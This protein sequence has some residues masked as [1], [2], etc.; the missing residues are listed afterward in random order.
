MQSIDQ[1]KDLF[2]TLNQL[3]Q[4]SLLKELSDGMQK[5]AEKYKEDIIVKCPF[6]QSQQIV[7]NGS[8]NGKQKYKCKDC[9][10]SYS[11]YTGTSS[12]GIKKRDK[13]EEYKSVLL[14]EGLFP[15]KKMASRIGISEQ[16]AFDWRHKILCTLTTDDTQFNGIVEIDDIWFLY[17]QKGR[18]GLKYSRKR[19]GSKRKGDNNY[20]AKLLVTSDREGDHDLSLTRI[21]RL[22]SEDI[23]RKVGGR[24]KKEATLVSDKH[25]SI[26]AFAK[27]NRIKHVSF[28]SS[29]HG[30]DKEHHVQLVNNMASRL[31]NFINGNLKG[32]STKHLQCYANWFSFIEGKKGQSEIIKAANQ[33]LDQ[34]TDSWNTFINMESMY[35]KF[36]EEYSVRTYRCPT[37]RKW[38]NQPWN[39][40]MIAAM[41]YV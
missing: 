25:S 6:C 38:K 3:D 11:K 21:G 28:K 29:Q 41:S 22:K 40:D 1:I 4:V 36:I 39:D 32:V 13:F 2:K 9:N 5:D 16:T 26:S 14:T 10:K 7:K 33:Q 15:L 8:V 24:F 37:K 35:K 17:S 27:K 34:K 23:Q 20:Q 18:Q 31:K 12:H 30:A 19:G